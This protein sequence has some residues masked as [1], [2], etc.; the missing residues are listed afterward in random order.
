DPKKDKIVKSGSHKGISYEVHHNPD[1]AGDHK[2][3]HNHAQM[4]FK[5]AKE[6]ETHAKQRI[7]HAKKNKWQ[8]YE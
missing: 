2:Y 5:T 3:G 8:G 7:E 4:S 6:A 1:Y